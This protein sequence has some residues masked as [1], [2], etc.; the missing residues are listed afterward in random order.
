VWH[1]LK[2]G[3]TSQNCIFSLADYSFSSGTEKAGLRNKDTLLTME[4]T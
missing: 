1:L 3:D 4:K 2:C